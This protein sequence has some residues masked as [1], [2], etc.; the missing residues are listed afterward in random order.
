MLLI[1]EIAEYKICNIVCNI[2]NFRNGYTV[3]NMLFKKISR[4]NWKHLTNSNLLVCKYICKI[5]IQL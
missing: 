1:V 5:D 2:R 4:L 3:G